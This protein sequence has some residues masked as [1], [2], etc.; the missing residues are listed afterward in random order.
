[1]STCR[2]RI[3]RPPP[4]ASGAC[5]RGAKNPATTCFVPALPLR[6]SF[7]GCDRQPSSPPQRGA[8]RLCRLDAVVS[9]GGGCLCT[10]VRSRLC[11]LSRKTNRP[12]SE[13]VLLIR[14]RLSIKATNRRLAEGELTGAGAER[15]GPAPKVRSP[16]LVVESSV[17]AA[18]KDQFGALSAQRQVCRLRCSRHWRAAMGRRRGDDRPP[19]RFFHQPRSRK[20]TKPSTD[21]RAGRPTSRPQRPADSV[22]QSP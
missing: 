5:L 9:V 4:S 12:F 18:R 15:N 10:A 13:A 20:A 22:A 6:E 7:S 19:R 8:G 14:C 3:S 2:R 17:G 11:P 21:T 16:E 1:M